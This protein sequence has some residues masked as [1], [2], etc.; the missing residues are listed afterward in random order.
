MPVSM[1]EEESHCYEN[2]QAERLNGILK[3]EYGPGGHSARRLWHGAIREAVFLYTPV[4]PPPAGDLL[5]RGP[6]KKSGGLPLGQAAEND[7]LHLR[8]GLLRIGDRIPGSRR[9]G[10]LIKIIIYLL[11]K[12]F[13]KPH[14]LQLNN[15]TRLFAVCQT[16][17]RRRKQEDGEQ[18]APG[19]QLR[20]ADC[21]SNTPAVP[22][23]RTTG[24]WDFIREPGTY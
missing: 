1:T 15:Y 17:F 5:R 22:A 23:F 19:L 9:I 10:D 20:P 2:A 8:I 21:Q 14:A 13:I 4:T 18:R 7:L 6:G 16:F 24:T 11:K 12:N 3:Q